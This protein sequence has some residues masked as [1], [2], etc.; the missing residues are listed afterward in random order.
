MAASQDATFLY[1]CYRGIVCLYVTCN[2]S[3]YTT[4][5]C[6]NRKMAERI[7]LIFTMETDSPVLYGIMR[8]QIPKD[9]GLSFLP[10]R[11]KVRW[12]CLC[13]SKNVPISIV[14]L[15]YLDKSLNMRARLKVNSDSLV[16]M[17]M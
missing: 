12:I 3:R 6:G 11:G 10:S 15:T 1:R 17:G 14:V 16:D 4:I 5:R 2:V 7:E 9:E 13:L 8:V